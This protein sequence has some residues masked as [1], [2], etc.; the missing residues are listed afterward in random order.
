[1]TRLQ[2]RLLGL[3]YGRLRIGVAISDELGIGAAELGHVPR[4]DD[5]QA[6]RVVAA[7]AVREGVA[8]IVV[9]LPLNADGSRGASVRLVKNF[10]VVL[11]RATALPVEWC[12]E[13]YSSSEAEAE[14]RRLDRWP[15]PPGA[16]DARA[17]AVL[18]RRYLGGEDGKSAAE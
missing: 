2:G 16:V 9:G 1:M 14:L 3:D 11:R 6:A 5:L 8:G 7:L 13:R 4:Q 17:A 12:D 15:A 10:V 18:L